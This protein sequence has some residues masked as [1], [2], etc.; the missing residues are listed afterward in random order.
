MKIEANRNSLSND[1][2]LRLTDAGISHVHN[3][4]LPQKKDPSCVFLF[5]LPWP[6]QALDLV[7]FFEVEC[8]ATVRHASIVHHVTNDRCNA[9]IEFV[10]AD[11]GSR[12]CLR[13]TFIYNG[14]E[15]CT[16][17][18]THGAP[19]A[20][21]AIESDPM[22]FYAK[23]KVLGPTEANESTDTEVEESNPTVFSEVVSGSINGCVAPSHCEGGND[24]HFDC[25]MAATNID[26][27]HQQQTLAQ[28]EIESNLPECNFLVTNID[29]EEEQQNLD[30][31]I[32]AQDSE[33]AKE[34]GD[35]EGGSKDA[36]SMHIS[37][38]ALLQKE[39]D[40]AIRAKD[41]AKAASLHA[42]LE[43]LEQDG[44]DDTVIKSM[45]CKEIDLAIET[46]N[47]T[48]AATIQAR[49]E[50]LEN[51]SLTLAEAKALLR[52]DLDNELMEAIEAKLF[53]KAGSIQTRI[54]SLEKGA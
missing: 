44:S 33:E 11:D 27:S 23:S 41:F 42:T 52:K 12:V 26:R 22:L 9:H 2:F 28:P 47:F 1:L 32:T 17:M 37:K 15:I 29:D 43:C 40:E 7:Q 3:T 34:T 21:P 16:T 24:P 54:E 38:L 19:P 13:G 8:Q 30:A 20:G 49:I 5:G 10:N 48:R 53:D 39:L 50:G 31:A 36:V 4:K 6:I 14:V 51:G 25:V 46:K 45:M 35:L 18:D